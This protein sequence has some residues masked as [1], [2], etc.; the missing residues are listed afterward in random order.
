MEK[1]EG[2]RPVS[3]C[4]HGYLASV[5]QKSLC[6]IHEAGRKDKT[7]WLQ[8]VAGRPWISMLGK[9]C[10]LINTHDFSR[11]VHAQQCASLPFSACRP[12]IGLF[13]QRCGA[14]G[15]RIR[16]SLSS[17]WIPC[18]QAGSGWLILVVSYGNGPFIISS[19]PKLKHSP[20]S[21][22]RTMNS[23]W[24]SIQ[25]WPFWSRTAHPDL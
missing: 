22:A 20:Y 13:C 12:K 11:W 19:I 15:I 23:L 5:L 25:H 6:L 14:P 10:I 17:K 24:H 9:G 21:I 16:M 4:S 18:L 7:Y 2:C 1:S 8:W 3:K